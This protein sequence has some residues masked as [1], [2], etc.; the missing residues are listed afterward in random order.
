MASKQGTAESESTIASQV[1]GDTNPEQAAS[2]H[3]EG[4]T[5]A[6]RLP[7]SPD[8][9][10]ARGGL[11]TL[12]T[13]SVKTPGEGHPP[14]GSD[15]H[16]SCDSASLGES[17]TG[18]NGEGDNALQQKDGND[19]GNESDEWSD[20]EDDEVHGLPKEIKAQFGNVSLHREAQQ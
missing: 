8:G 10:A 17:A 6:V 19:D 12:P 15:A 13:D 2:P 9:A 7:T 1:P 11:P 18:E 20:V 5:T 16:S 3:R 4:T 14:P